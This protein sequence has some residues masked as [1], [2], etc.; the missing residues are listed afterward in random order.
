MIR[1]ILCV[2]VPLG[3]TGYARLL[4]VPQITTLN[5]QMVL[6]G[7]GETKILVAGFGVFTHLGCPTEWRCAADYLRECQ[8]RL[9]ANLSASSIPANAYAPIAVTVVTPAPGGRHSAPYVLTQYQSLAIQSAFLIYE[10]VG[11]MLYAS[12]P[13]AAAS[14]PN[15]VVS[16]NPATA[17]VG[18]CHR[19]GQRPKCARCFAD[20]AYLYVALD[21]DHTIQRINLAG[22]HFTEDER[23]SLFQSIRSMATCR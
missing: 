5:S 2:S 4:P 19:R 3:G 11:K 8:T 22:K 18:A 10:P 15:T 6:A 16:I 9:R 14:N 12:V 1:P 23:P 21:A 17:T 13:A 7:V 20:G